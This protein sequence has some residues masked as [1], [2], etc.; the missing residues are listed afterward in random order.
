MRAF[1]YVQETGNMYDCRADGPSLIATG[2][3][4]QPPYVNDPQAQSLKARGPIPRGRYRIGR[5]FDHVRLGADCMFLE[6]FDDNAMSGRSGFFIHG[7]NSYGNATASHGCIVLNRRFR[8]AIG[9]AYPAILTVVR[10]EA[11]AK[12]MAHCDVLPLGVV[13][14]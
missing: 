2:Y 14:V 12:R 4:G 3:S 10:D 6:P 8:I 1:L 11:T 13:G 5:R 9:S 7:D